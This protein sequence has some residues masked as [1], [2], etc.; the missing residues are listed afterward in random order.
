MKNTLQYYRLN[1]QDARAHFEQMAKLRISVFKEFPYLYLGN[2]EYE[3]NYL[4]TYFKS[5]YSMI[6][7]VK[8]NQELVGM[9]TCIKASDETTDL[10]HVFAKFNFN[11]QRILYLGESLLLPKYRGLGLGKLFFKERE[12]FGRSLGI[13]QFSFCA[14]TREINHRMR[15]NNYSPL[16]S[17]WEKMGYRPIPLMTTELSWR[18]IDQSEDTNKIMQYWMKS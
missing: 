16:N 7:L 17:F 15:P 12:D 18:D 14:V 8:E 11:P 13:Q 3:K 6:F 1:G 4:E 10:N 5:K 9:T 2:Q